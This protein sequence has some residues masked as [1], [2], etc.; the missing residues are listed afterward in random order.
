MQYKRQLS[1]TINERTNEGFQLL[2]L[3]LENL[4]RHVCASGPSTFSVNE[5]H[6]KLLYEFIPG[7]LFYMALFIHDNM[8]LHY[9]R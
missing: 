2:C 3:S 5:T 6:D 7:R 8:K 4:S 9:L 1:T